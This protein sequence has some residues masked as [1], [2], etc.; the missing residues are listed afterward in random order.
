MSNGS[1][2]N[3]T[4]GLR[5]VEA[6]PA[7]TRIAYRYCAAFVARTLDRFPDLDSGIAPFEQ[8]RARANRLKAELDAACEERDRTRRTLENT[9]DA[10]EAVQA[11]FGS[12]RAAVASHHRAF[13]RQVAVRQGALE[14]MLLASEQAAGELTA[15]RRG[16]GLHQRRLGAMLVEEAERYETSIADLQAEN[17][18][19]NAE[20]VAMTREV[21]ESESCTAQEIQNLKAEIARLR[22]AHPSETP[23]ENGKGRS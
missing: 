8:A 12:L 13:D 9:L 21:A 11:E 7:L 15:L 17:E 18:R 19:L 3:M 16:V 20:L 5:P 23:P 4:V 10:A 6:L 1:S 22:Q 14:T 2:A